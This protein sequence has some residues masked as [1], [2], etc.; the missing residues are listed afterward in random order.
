MKKNSCRTFIFPLFAALIC[1]SLSCFSS[2]QTAKTT[3]G[4]GITTGAY[5]YEFLRHPSNQWEDHYFLIIAPSIGRAATERRLGLEGRLK[6]L[7]DVIDKDG[8]SALWFPTE[9]LKVQAYKNKFIDIAFTA[10]F[11]IYY[12]GAFS[13]ILSR[14]I[15]KFLTFYG[16][17]K[18]LAGPYLLSERDFEQHLMSTLNLGTEINL[19]R[20]ISVLF[21][22]E[23]WLS[24][25]WLIDRELTRYSAGVSF[26]FPLQKK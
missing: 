20:N 12:P 22:I 18:M 26:H 14:D 2:L 5:R 9:E 1:C 21:E 11:W 23:K 19:N 7:T 15:N 4:F 3:D 13:I 16:Q 17:Y 6:L 24:E 25:K 10:E 8:E